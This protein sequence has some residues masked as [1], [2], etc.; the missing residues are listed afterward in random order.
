MSRK[1]HEGSASTRRRCQGRMTS[2][3]HLLGG[4][5][6][7]FHTLEVLKP[8]DHIL[9]HHD[10]VGGEQSCRSLTAAFLGPKTDDPPLLR[11]LRTWGICGLLAA[12]GLGL[13]RVVEAGRLDCTYRLRITPTVKSQ[14]FPGQP[15]ATTRA[16]FPPLLRSARP[17]ARLVRRGNPPV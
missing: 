8:R 7:T 4:E 6:E 14:T 10:W 1:C 11:G 3:C 17:A 12:V 13:D 16:G 9:G 5:S 2:G 15:L